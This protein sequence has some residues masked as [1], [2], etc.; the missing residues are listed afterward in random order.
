MKL[1]YNRKKDKSPWGSS[2]GQTIYPLLIILFIFST[3]YFFIFGENGFYSHKSKI[4]VI[5]R[6]EEENHRIMEKITL[7]EEKNKGLKDM[8]PQDIE[9][10]AR[11]IPLKK[12]GDVIIKLYHNNWIN[13]LG[14]KYQRQYYKGFKPPPIKSGFINQYKMLITITVSLLIALLVTLLLPR[15]RRKASEGQREEIR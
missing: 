3:L 12:R 15:L 9:R 10:E 6:L 4:Q 2:K 7:L 8:N 1:R 13:E 5:T 11:R 14:K